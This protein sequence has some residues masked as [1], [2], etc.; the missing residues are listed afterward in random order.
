M[1]LQHARSS[2]LAAFL[3]L[4]TAATVTPA[5]AQDFGDYTSATLANK[6][7]TAYGSLSYDEALVYIDKCL[8]LYEREAKAMQLSLTEFPP[9]TPPEATAKY[10]ALND[11]GTCVFIKGQCLMSKGDKEGAKTAFRKLVDE[12]GF[13]QCWDP[14]GWFWKPADAAKQKLVE[15]EFDAQ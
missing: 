9:N 4:M 5:R 12:L 13:A 8:E 3:V 7:W 6:A 1:T 15:L 2:L 11:V 10:W 14:K